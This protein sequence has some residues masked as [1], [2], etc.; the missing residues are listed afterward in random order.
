MGYL[1]TKTTGFVNTDK[2]YYSGRH[3]MGPAKTFKTFQKSVHTENFNR[4]SIFNKEKLEVKMTCSVHYVLRPK[5]LKLLHDTCDVGYKP[6]LRTTIL[7]AL[8]GAATKFTI[9]E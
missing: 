6:I 2:I 4:L 5:D 7:A 8:K 3:W 1:K 9:D